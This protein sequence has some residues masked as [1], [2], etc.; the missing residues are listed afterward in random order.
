M[1]PHYTRTGE[2]HKEADAR[3]MVHGTGEGIDTHSAS[4][5]AACCISYRLEGR[6]LPPSRD[7]TP[8][9]RDQTLS[10][11]RPSQSTWDVSTVYSKPIVTNATAS[12]DCGNSLAAVSLGRLAQTRHKQL[13]PAE[14]V[15]RSAVNFAFIFHR[16][17]L[18]IS[19]ADIT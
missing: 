7:V 3:V 16:Q 14:N 19:N 5:T 13:K 12:I 1:R 6:E 9:A 4:S 15:N 2:L 18:R 17:A 10:R 8:R 11:W